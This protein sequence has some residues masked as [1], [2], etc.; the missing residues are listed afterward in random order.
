MANT[1]HSAEREI[2]IDRLL[3]KRRGYSVYEMVEIVNRSLEFEGYPPVSVTTI[4]RDLDTIRYRYRKRIESEKRSFNIYF[5]YA[6]PNFTIYNNVLTTGEMQHLHS[7]L[8][9]I[10]FVDPIQGTLMYEE[11]SQR[12]ADMLDIDPASDP[13]VLYKKI[14]SQND[15]KRFKALYQYIRTKTP[16]IITYS[17]DD[18][19]SEKEATIHPYFIMY[20]ESIYYLLGHTS[21]D[22]GPIKIP[23]STIKRM[24]PAYD[25]KFIPNNDFPLKDF[26]LKHLNKG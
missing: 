25:T 14:P 8:L 15:Q 23:I 13:I 11:L 3:H 26:Y 12:L 21:T 4:R 2:I 10:R 19:N 7:A 1:K 9:S 20:E 6:D 22:E 18:S 17:T 24:S 5:R 16:A